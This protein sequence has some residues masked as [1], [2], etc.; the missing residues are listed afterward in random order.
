MTANVTWKELE[1]KLSVPILQAIVNEFHFE[2][3]MPVQSAVIPVFCKN[4]DVAVEVK[5]FDTRPAQDQGRLSR[6]LSQYLK[7]F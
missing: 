3:V 5:Y 7:S 4:F 2:K 6:F 1:Y